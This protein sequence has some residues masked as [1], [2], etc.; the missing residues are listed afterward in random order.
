MAIHLGI[1]ILRIGWIEHLWQHRFD[2]HFDATGPEVTAQFS[3]KAFE[4]LSLAFMNFNAEDETAMRE[5]VQ[6]T[7]QNGN[8]SDVTGHGVNSCFR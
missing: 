1:P 8:Y 4:G 2:P 6:Q 5:L 3:V 7:L